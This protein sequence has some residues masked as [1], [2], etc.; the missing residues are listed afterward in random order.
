MGILKLLAK[1]IGDYENPN[2]LGSRFRA[3]RAKALEDLI[4]KVYLEKKKVR[5]IDLG[6]TRKYW[7][8]FPNEFFKRYNLEITVVNSLQEKFS[9]GENFIFFEGDVC[10]LSSIENQS[11]DIV[12]SNSVLE[13]VG[14]FEKM[15]K[16]SE[17][18]ARLGKI[19]YLQTPYFWFPIEPH[20][21]MPFFHWL[22]ESIRVWMVMHF[23]L[24]H[25]KRLRNREEAIESVRSVNIVDENKF[26]QLFPFCEIRKEKIL[27]FTKS[28]IGIRE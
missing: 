21:M 10:N 4:K 20:F 3:K 11:F 13:H 19:I 7:N 5:I 17:E 22:P 15:K 26:R 24:G 9:N 12:H 2:S 27:F 25:R 28:L 23:T 16:F 6:G 1:K 18:V 8:I 14:D